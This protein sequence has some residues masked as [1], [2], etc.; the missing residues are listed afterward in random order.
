MN[1]NAGST[2]MNCEIED[3]LVFIMLNYKPLINFFSCET[4]FPSAP[5]FGHLLSC[6]SLEAGFAE[7]HKKILKSIG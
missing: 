7:K 4:F 6:E 5:I 3:F 1:K 2:M